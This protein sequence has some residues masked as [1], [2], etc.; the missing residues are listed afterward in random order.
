MWV[1]HSQE[2]RILLHILE[3]LEKQ[4]VRITPNKYSRYYLQYTN[5]MI[6]ECAK[7]GEFLIY[8]FITDEISPSHK[9]TITTT[10]KKH[11]VSFVKKYGLF[12][13][14]IISEIHVKGVLKGVD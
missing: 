3:L 1:K 4:G 7:T 12:N 14:K 9:K 13:K 6:K 2:L 11:S 10:L 8:N 5:R